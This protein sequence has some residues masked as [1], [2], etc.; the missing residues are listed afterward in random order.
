MAVYQNGQLIL[1][2]DLSWLMGTWCVLKSPLKWKWTGLHYAL[3]CLKMR[4]STCLVEVCYIRFQ[5]NLSS[6]ESADGILQ[7]GIQADKICRLHEVVP[8]LLCIERI[9]R[10][11]AQ[12]RLCSVEQLHALAALLPGKVTP[13]TICWEGWSLA[14]LHGAR[15]VLSVLYVSQNRQRLLFYASLTV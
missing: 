6:S 12:D 11:L 14:V 13:Y 3:V 2:S 4:I 8:G 9:Y 15:F 1:C 10:Q 5:E 7:T